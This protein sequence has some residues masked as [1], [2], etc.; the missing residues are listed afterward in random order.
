MK[1]AIKIMPVNRK[2]N[3]TTL[4]D[5][6]DYYASRKKATHLFRIHSDRGRERH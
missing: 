6:C 3:L 4:L 1:C 5:A 2:Y